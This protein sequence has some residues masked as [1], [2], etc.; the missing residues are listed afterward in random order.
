VWRP[1]RREFGDIR[2][3]LDGFVNFAPRHAMPAL[4]SWA[5]VFTGGMRCDVTSPLVGLSQGTLE[6]FYIWCDIYLLQLGSHLVAVVG[7]LV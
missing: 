1:Q 7:R 6:L 4:F 5:Y 2:G 3:A